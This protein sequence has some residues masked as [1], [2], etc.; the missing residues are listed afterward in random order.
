MELKVIPVIDRGLIG[1]QQLIRELL[2][3]CRFEY[4]QIQ[5]TLIKSFYERIYWKSIFEC[6]QKLYCSK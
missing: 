6:N 1:S 3:N 2:E 4:D 5:C